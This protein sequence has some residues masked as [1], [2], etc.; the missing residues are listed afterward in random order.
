MDICLDFEFMSR[1]HGNISYDAGCWVLTDLKSSNGIIFNGK[2]IQ[3]LVLANG[4]TFQVGALKF[5]VELLS[6]ERPIEDFDEVT[7]PTIVNPLGKENAH[8]TVSAAPTQKISDSVHLNLKSHSLAPKPTST[9]SAPAVKVSPA[10]QKI[11]SQA[12]QNV[13]KAAMAPLPSASSVGISAQATVVATRIQVRVPMLQKDFSSEFLGFHESLSKSAKRKLE[14]VVTWQGQVYDIKEFRSGQVITAGPAGQASLKIPTLKIPWTLAKVSADRVQC[15]IPEGNQ[16]SLAKNG[17]SFGMDALLASKQMSQQGSGFALKMDFQEVV[18]VGLGNG[19]EVHLRYV[20]ASSPLGNGKNEFEG[21]LKQSIVS[22]AVLHSV[23]LLIVLLGAPAQVEGPK[24]KN[25]PERFARL[26]VEKPKPKPTP[27]PPKLEK[28]EVV[29]K[30][31]PKPKIEKKVV[32]HKIQPTP[33]VIQKV[34]KFPMIVKQPVPKAPPPLK[35]ESLGALAALGAIS[36]KAQPNV[37]TNIN[38]NKNAGGMQSKAINAGGIIGA[39]PSSNGALLAGGGQ[40]VK[41]KGL[42]FGTGTGYGMQGLKG[43]AGARA[44]AGAVVGEPKLAKSVKVE[45]LTRAQVMA[46]IQKYL[47]EVQHC[48][49]RILLTDSNLSGRMEFEWDISSGGSVQA[50]RVKRSTVNNGDALG[51][52]VKGIFSGMKFPTA[53]NGQSTTPSIGFPFGRL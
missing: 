49:E 42:G 47:S 3:K 27:I 22:S 7:S 19:I 10:V 43:N 26:L 39:L 2:K 9:G 52:C 33:K 11:P 44:V 20:P 50:V 30:D 23:L 53:S 5:H 12:P 46:V 35:V 17:Q 36:D 29:K 13:H 38:I 51:E 41:T 8:Q 14:A 28:K 45:G 25:V 40:H 34:N 18:R 24:L 4:Q 32:V 16:A 6:E 1:A 21:V 48:Y 31:L 15:F 37:V